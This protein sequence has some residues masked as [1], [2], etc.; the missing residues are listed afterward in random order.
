MI[1]QEVSRILGYT[2]PEGAWDKS[3]K[4]LSKEG[5]ITIKHVIEILIVLLKKQEERE[6]E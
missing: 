3:F 5:R 2:I 6:N 4:D 1:R